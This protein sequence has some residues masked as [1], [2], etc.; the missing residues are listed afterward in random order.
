MVISV[1][2]K[3][4]VSCN[5]IKSREGWRRKTWRTPPPKKKQGG[6]NINVRTNVLRSQVKSQR[7]ENLLII[8][9]L[10]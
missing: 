6:R 1:K 8:M 10:Y 2:L 4:F 7:K 3:S 5:V 9:L